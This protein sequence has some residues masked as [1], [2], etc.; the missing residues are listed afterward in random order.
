MRG[1]CGA[2]R[3]AG[4]E[5][6]TALPWPAD[7]GASDPL[8]G[9]RLRGRGD[10]VD[11]SGSRRPRLTPDGRQRQY[12][13]GPASSL[14]KHGPGRRTSAAWRGC[15]LVVPATSSPSPAA[16]MRLP[17]PPSR[18]QRQDLAQR[19]PPCPPPAA[20]IEGS[21]SPACGTRWILT[22]QAYA[23][24]LR[25][26][27]ELVRRRRAKVAACKPSDTYRFAPNGVQLQIPALHAANPGT[28]CLRSTILRAHLGVAEGGQNSY[29]RARRAGSRSRRP[30]ST[31][32]R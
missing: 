29:A 12:K 1:A 20:T 28:Y 21:V 27:G 25:G 19:A 15:E 22:A 3:R 11:P 9:R 2:Y 10:H 16:A 14:S 4:Q 5:V 17:R 18:H 31:A 23:A 8:D 24:Y 32:R 26:R 30:G 7:P 13:A 6:P